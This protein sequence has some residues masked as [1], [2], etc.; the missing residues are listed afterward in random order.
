MANTFQRE[1]IRGVFTAMDADGDGALTESDFQELAARWTAVRADGDH[2]RLTRVM[3]GWWSTLR[4][5]A[6]ADGDGRVTLEEVLAVVDVLPTMP[7]AVNAT[8][9]AMFET[10]DANG[11]G[12]ISRQ[13]YR[14]L[15]EAWT[16][17][18]TDT[19]LI[20]P[21]LDLDGDGYLSRAEF[22][23]LW[24]DFWAGETPGTPGAWLFGLFPTEATRLPPGGEAAPP[25]GLLPAAPSSDGPPTRRRGLPRAPPSEK[26]P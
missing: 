26:A 22:L 2:A 4:A 16:G 1:K 15:I 17:R 23:L 11:D 8:A 20:F 25:H 6:D 18:P 9:E 14:T 5:A 10:V 21:R 19:D 12:R 3:T 7:E 24:R 13:E